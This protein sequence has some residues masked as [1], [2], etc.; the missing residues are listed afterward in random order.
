MARI[1]L[2][3]STL[4][5]A[6]GARYTPQRYQYIPVGILKIIKKKK[7]T[8][9][10]TKNKIE[11]GG[12]SI[13]E[14]KLTGRYAYRIAGSNETKA[15]LVLPNELT[16]AEAE[17]ELKKYVDRLNAKI[18][19]TVNHKG[20]TLTQ[21]ENLYTNISGVKEDECET[22]MDG[23]LDKALTEDEAKKTIE[24]FLKAYEERKKAAEDNAK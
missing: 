13:K 4:F 9:K 1:A 21:D 8:T 23:Y 11:Y 19:L 20:V 15:I 7:E 3:A 16:D 18:I 12:Y 22:G 17:R 2:I 6:I 24:E 14:E 10:M 5:G